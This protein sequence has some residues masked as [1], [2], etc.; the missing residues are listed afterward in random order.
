MLQSQSSELLHLNA[1]SWHCFHD[2]NF[3]S[4]SLEDY[5]GLQQSLNLLIDDFS[6]FG[7]LLIHYHLVSYRLVSIRVQNAGVLGSVIGNKL[8]RE[9][10]EFTVCL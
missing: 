10:D 2:M 5:S 8:L 1:A 9:R 6:V 4:S 3:L 7:F